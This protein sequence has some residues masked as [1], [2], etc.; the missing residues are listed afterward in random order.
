MKKI[1]TLVVAVICFTSLTAQASLSD[2]QLI[3]AALQEGKTPAEAAA[4]VQYY[5]AKE[6]LQPS[7]RNSDPG[8]IQLFTNPGF[9]SGNF[10]GWTGYIGDNTVSSYGSLQNIQTGIFSTVMDAHLNDG[11]ARQTIISSAFGNDSLGNFPTV[12]PGLGNYTVRLGGVTPNY[13][14]EEL[15]QTWLVDSAQAYL[16]FSYAVVLNDVGHPPGENPYFRYEVVDSNNQ[17]I[18]ARFV[19]VTDSGFVQTA[20]DVYSLSWTTDSVSLLAY[21]GTNVTLRCVAAGCIQ[22]GH[23]AYAY[24]DAF[25]PFGTSVKENTTASFSIFPNPCNGIF[26]LDFGSPLKGNETFFVVNMLGQRVDVPAEIKNSGWKIDMTTMEPG[27]YFV[28]VR[29]G[30]SISTRKIIIQ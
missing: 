28:E 23:F 14:G 7:Q 19:N 5:H 20:P 4:L 21:I 26:N 10:T 17:V 6:N 18:A 15:E 29:S 30:N 13:Q 16:L 2:D 3:S 25:Y 27:I 1:Y 11:N 24:I 12:P 9:E 8:T 22:S